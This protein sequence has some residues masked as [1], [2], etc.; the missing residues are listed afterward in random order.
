MIRGLFRQ[1]AGR[2]LPQLAAFRSQLRPLL[3]GQSRLAVNRGPLRAFSANPLLQQEVKKFQIKPEEKPR[4]Q[5]SFTC[6]VCQTRSTHEVSKQAYHKGTVL[7]QCPGC[8]N[9]HLIADHLKVS[10]PMGETQVFVLRF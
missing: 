5:L 7:I 2:R 9:R 6:K 4:Y 3:L 8:K 10:L 1:A